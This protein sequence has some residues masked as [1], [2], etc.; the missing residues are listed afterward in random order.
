MPIY[1]YD[2]NGNQ[3][4]HEY[5]PTKRERR[6]SYY[7]WKTFYNNLNK[8]IKSCRYSFLGDEESCDTTI[9]LRDRIINYTIPKVDQKREQTKIIILNSMGLKSKEIIE[10]S[11]GIP[12]MINNYIY[13]E[14]GKIISQVDSSKSRI[15]KKLFKYDSFGREIEQQSLDDG[16]LI[17]KALNEY[18][19][20]G[21]TEKIIW[22]IG[23]YVQ[24]LIENYD[25]NNNLIFKVYTQYVDT[26]RRQIESIKKTSY[27]LNDTGYP[28]RESIVYKRYSYDKDN[29]Y[30]AFPEWENA[31]SIIYKY[32]FDEKSRMIKKFEYTDH[33][34]GLRIQSLDTIE[35]FD[36]E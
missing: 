5:N 34:D 31:Y 36:Y 23:S 3:I 18:D 28:I 22:F 21:R 32:E 7:R 33:G 2:L 26:N 20:D 12:L 15:K 25:I 35:Y 9:Y 6:D 27:E 1:K 11:L 30:V 17:Y 4:D 13:N 19:E 24:E 8:E 16:Q 10:D 14:N 29:S